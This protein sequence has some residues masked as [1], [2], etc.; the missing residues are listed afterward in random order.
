MT[1]ASLPSDAQQA[2]AIIS[3]S[4][5]KKIKKFHKKRPNHSGS[6]LPIVYNSQL[7]EVD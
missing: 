3:E 7:I 5:I 6:G 1:K 2:G 4:V